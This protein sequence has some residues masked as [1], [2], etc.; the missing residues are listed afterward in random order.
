MSRSPETQAELDRL[1]REIEKVGGEMM[2]GRVNLFARE[3]LGVRNAILSREF[4]TPEPERTLT[5]TIPA[6]TR[7]RVYESL[8]G[9]RVRLTPT[10]PGPEQ[11]TGR[12][13]GG[14]G[15]SFHL[16]SAIE[17]AH[18][19]LLIAQ[20]AAVREAEEI[21]ARKAKADASSPIRQSAEDLLK[22]LGL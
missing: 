17:E 1:D 9:W 18:A 10:I 22:E 11:Y 16:A 8:T 6:N 12:I 14:D 21:R 2:N 19:N 4:H 3:L 15:E 20:Q 7:L 13:V 5:L